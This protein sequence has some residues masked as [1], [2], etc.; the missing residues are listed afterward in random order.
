MATTVA[1]HAEIIRRRLNAQGLGQYDILASNITTTTA[2]SVVFTDGPTTLAPGTRIGIGTELMLVRSYVVAT[3]TATVIRGFLGTTAAT[4][5][6]ADLIEIAP[7]FPLPGIVDTM[8]EEIDSWGP[9]LFKVTTAVVPLAAGTRTYDLTGAVAPLFLLDVEVPPPTSV[10]PGSGAR[11]GLAMRLIRGQATSDFAS[12]FAVQLT[13]DTGYAA[14][15]RVT[16]AE[17]FDT[18]TFATTTDLEATIGVRRSWLDV[19]TYGVL[20]RLMSGREIGRLDVHAAS[21]QARAADVPVGSSSAAVLRLLQLRDRRMA[22][23]ANK[24]RSDY[25]YKV[26]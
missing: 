14:D 11:T 6:A 15:A 8:R 23:E 9:Q 4:H 25:P 24:L 2:T 26:A 16:W 18:T 5:T 22:E 19:L 17:K 7:R 13:S 20:W 10:S 3:K 12:G 1:Q 21:E